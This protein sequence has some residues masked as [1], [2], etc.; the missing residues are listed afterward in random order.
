MII[1]K[2]AHRIATELESSIVE[3]ELFYPTD[4]P[5]KCVNVDAVGPI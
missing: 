2:S 3:L 4:N 5:G 1:H